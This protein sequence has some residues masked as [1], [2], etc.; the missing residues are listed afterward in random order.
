MGTLSVPKR[1]LSSRIKF[2]LGTNGKKRADESA[3]HACD[4]RQHHADLLSRGHRHLASHLLHESAP[5]PH[6]SFHL[7]GVFAN[8]KLPTTREILQ[9]AEIHAAILE[10]GG[11]ESNGAA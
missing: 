5:E 6:N 2:D 9:A 1:L 11:T 8:Q 3:H 7:S 4:Y 10:V